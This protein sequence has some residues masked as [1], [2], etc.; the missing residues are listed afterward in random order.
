MKKG[1]VLLTVFAGLL[2]GLTAS[3]EAPFPLNWQGV[4][5][6][7]PEGNFWAA[8]CVYNGKIYEFGG[9]PYVLV[10]S[11][12]IA[13]GT[14]NI[15]QIYDPA[16]DTWTSG[17]PMPTARYL[18]T[19]VEVGGKIYV[20]GGRTVNP[21]DGTGGP[22]DVNEMYDPATNTWTTKAAMRGSFRGHASVNVNGKIYVFGGNT[23]SAQ[24]TVG[25]YDPA[26]DSW[27]A[28]TNMPNARAY[29][30]AVWVPAKSRVY[31]L[32][33]YNLG[34]TAAS[35]YGNA[36]TYNPIANEWDATPIPLLG[37]IIQ[38][39]CAFDSTAGK[40]YLFSGAAFDPDAAAGNS[41][42]D[43]VEVLDTATDTVAMFANKP[44]SPLD[45][46][47]TNAAF[48]GG[49]IYITSDHTVLDLLDTATGEWYQPI[50]PA[51]MDATYKVDTAVVGG[52]LYVFNGVDNDGYIGTGVNIYDPASNTWSEG[53]AANPSPLFGGVAGVHGGKVVLSGGAVD[54]PSGETK[55]FD[56]ATGAFSALNADPT[57][58]YNAA[59]AVVGD[60]LF[61]FGGRDAAAAPINV[62][63]AFNVT[64][65]AWSSKANL[66]TV[67]ADAA[68]VAVGTKIYIVGGVKNTDG[69]S[70][71]G[72]VIIYDTAANSFSTGAAMSAAVSRCT[73][74]GFG[75]YVIVQGGQNVWTRAGA[76]T[77]GLSPFLQ[78][79]DT[80]TNTWSM[81]DGLFSSWGSSAQTIGSKLYILAGSDGSFVCSRTQVAALAAGPSLGI[82]VTPASQSV[83]VGG[84]V[85][86][87][88]TLS[89][90]QAAD[91]S[92]ALASA[93]GTIATV[94]ATVTVLAS[95]TTATF[96]ATGVG[97]GGP[98]N[99]SATLPGDLGG[100][101]GSAQLTV[102]GTT[103]A[104]TPGTLP[105]QVGNI[106]VMNAVIGAAQPGAVVINLASSNTAV[107]AVPATVSVAA[108]Q[109]QGGFTVTGIAEGSAIITATLPA[110]L[111]GGTAVATVNVT[112]GQV[113]TIKYLVPS[114]AHLPGAGGTKWRTDIAAVNRNAAEAAAITATYYP[115]SGSAVVRNASLPAGATVEWRDILVANFGFA[116]DANTKGTMIFETPVPLD[117]TSRTY[118]QKSATETFGQSYP[119]LLEVHALN[120]ALS[121]TL[122][123]IKKNAG[124]RTNVG[125]ANLGDAAAQVRFTL[126]GASG[127]QLGNPV[128][129]NVPAQRW[130]QQNDIFA[131]ATVTSADI[132][133]AKVEVLTADAK[134]WTYASVI[135]ATTGDPTT[136]PNQKPTP[137]LTRYVPSVAHLPGAGG[138]KWRSDVAFVNPSASSASITLTYS[139]TAGNP[140]VVRNATLDPGATVELA[141]ILVSTFGYA[142]GANTKGTLKVESN[143]PLAITSRTYNQKSAT[144]TFGQFYP[145]LSVLRTLGTNQTGTL[146]QLKKNAGFR[147]NVGVTNVGDS[148]TAVQIRLFDANGNQAGNPVTLNV[149]AGKWVQRDDIFAAAG[150]ASA[151]IAYA[152]VDVTEAG[153]KVWAYASVIDNTTGDPTT[154][155]VLRHMVDLD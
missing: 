70:L 11:K 139:D 76:L 148:D 86:Y 91:V 52:K 124:F 6:P 24:K 18:G 155:G 137:E 51:P 40:I 35:Y 147:T 154:I 78:I 97:V 14:T 34:S 138:T 69:S 140:A 145:A 20:M 94:P 85:T 117:I 65:N 29:G 19:A 23:G 10:P 8:Q 115:E 90:A 118:N 80:T 3:A 9:S 21:S 153:A 104:L 48:I 92:V 133:W 106:G 128:T 59:G 107:A 62:T 44:P 45:R 126:F 57:A 101:S 84:N 73:A 131:A 98:V 43:A 129:L 1:L 108:T 5:S 93:N 54:N 144:E 96:S 111:G 58:S 39:A 89:A 56:P 32:G 110:A 99:I 33:G 123:Q 103:L 120:P 77:G 30:Y 82:T 64:S 68:A 60:Q 127:A 61:V 81:D 47:N 79:Y 130:V 16:T 83:V 63:R 88:V 26:A 42:T 38:F 41:S 149:T 95:S 114:V 87:T 112:G 15:T 66:P 74:A 142:A 72:D 4:K 55:L 113:V 125:A 12:G 135:D 136:V 49:K 67:L 134:I 27:T 116:A 22:V 37:K 28:G 143:V 105:I 146:P 36:I 75:S 53:P 121:A 109:T 132:A 31:Y 13:A 46:S 150:V 7:K 151:D 50:Q 119:A 122:P 100:A 71:N 25:I 2:V 102:T 17:A 152:T 141:D